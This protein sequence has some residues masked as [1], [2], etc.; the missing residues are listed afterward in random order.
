M[1]EKGIR[2]NEAETNLAQ[3]E[4][5]GKTAMLISV[6]KKESELMKLKQISL[7]LKKKEKLQCL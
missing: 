4:K 2:T 7:N 6:E 5:E 3:F 1:S